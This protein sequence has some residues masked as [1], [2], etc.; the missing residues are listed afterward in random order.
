MSGEHSEIIL[1]SEKKSG[2]SLTFSMGEMALRDQNGNIVPLRRQAAEM[3]AVLAEEP[4]KVVARQDLIDRVWG[5][6]AVT[7]DSLTQG[8]SDIRKAL[9]D[10]DR[11]I[12]RTHPRV[13]YSLNIGPA[14][15]A[16]VAV[17]R[18]SRWL[19]IVIAAVALVI[20]G[21]GIWFTMGEP[22][23]AQ[24]PSIAVLAFDDLSVAPDAGYLSDAISEGIITE[25]ARFSAFATIARNSSF[26]FRELP[27]DIREIGQKL[28]AEFI[29]EGSPAKARR[30]AAGHRS[31]DRR[32]NRHAHLGRHVSRDVGR[33]FFVPGT[34]CSW[35]RLYRGRH[36]GD[37]FARCRRPQH[38][39]SLGPSCQGTRTASFSRP[40]WQ[41]ERAVPFRGSHQGRSELLLRVSGHGDS[42]TAIRPG[43]PLTPPLATSPEPARWD[44]VKKA[45]S[46]A[47]DNYLVHYLMGHLHADAGDLADARAK[48]DKT[49]ELNPSFSNAFVSA[50][51]LRVFT[52]DAEGAV[53]DIRHAMTI[54]PLHPP[55][56]HGRLATALWAA[57]ECEA[58]QEALRDVTIMTPRTRQ[59]HA[60]VSVCLGE[61]EAAKASMKIYL[62]QRPG[63]TIAVERDNYLGLWTAPG[64]L[65]RWLEAMRAAGMP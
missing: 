65:D 56:F 21:V 25:L 7:E 60:A 40:R 22:A 44:M 45:A 58:A 47:P 11:T 14:T 20:A 37:L 2:H 54:D 30:P 42:I 16:R 12:L 31:I 62:E 33:H 43:T 19:A 8:I 10:T 29:L 26:T 55:W 28:N 13:G 51:N 4:G 35:H 38:S 53:S 63:Q 57:N 6:A 27:H 61:V 15:E 64:Q 5:K 46:I 59:A 3:L 39:E 23:D 18:T 9:G 1:K 41:R 48:Y 32:E 49:K 34:D 36:S 24:L 52:G 50:A 17:A